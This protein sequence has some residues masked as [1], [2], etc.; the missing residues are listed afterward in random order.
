[1]YKSLLVEHSLFKDGQSKEIYHALV[2]FENACC[3]YVQGAKNLCTKMIL[4]SLRRSVLG[5]QASKRI[6]KVI[7]RIWISSRMKDYGFKTELTLVKKYNA[8][9]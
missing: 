8:C 3:C 7:C 1:M 2:H 5:K 6:H 9:S 4:H